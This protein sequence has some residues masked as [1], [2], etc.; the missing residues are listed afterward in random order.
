MAVRSFFL[1]NGSSGQRYDRGMSLR[2]LCLIGLLG[3]IPAALAQNKQS[4]DPPIQAT[5]CQLEIH[6]SAYDHKLVEVRGRVYFGKFDFVIDSS[7]KPHS[8]GRVW[9]DLGGDVQAP[10]EYWGVASFLPKHKGMDVKVRGISIPLVHDALLDK[11]VND[12]GATRFRKPNG[13]GC[14][15]ECLFYEV[16]ATLRGRFFSGTKGGFG[17]EEC[18]HLL[19]VEEVL[20]VSSKRTGVPAGGEFQCVSDRWQPRADELRAFSAIPGCSLRDDFKNCYAVL[21]KH[22]ADNIKP[23]EGI[24]YPGPWMSPDMMVTYKFTGGFIQEIGQP[25]EMKASSSVTREVCRPVSPPK[26]ASHHV[27]CNFYRSGGLEDTNTTLAQ[28]KTVDAG[29]EVW[30]AS[31][32]AQVGWSAYE[33]SVRHWGLATASPVILSKCEPW[34]AGTDGTGNEQQWGYCT[35][36]ARDDLQQVT[37]Q[38]HKISYLTKSADRLQKAPWVA[39]GVEANVCHVSEPR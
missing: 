3:A 26:P 34:P 35:W 14:G 22:W 31:D 19:V 15:S 24:D 18:C 30:R 36:F 1:G 8:Q 13:D 29:K 39:T 21:A 25:I 10:G 23:S 12:V 5:T 28:Q 11:F 32:M 16:T 9:L 20:G 38:L 6:P 33:D 37:V 17:M 27:H 7:C 4:V 2:A